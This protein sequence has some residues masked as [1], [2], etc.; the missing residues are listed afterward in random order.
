M[1]RRC[2]YV[3]AAVESG[4]EEEEEESGSSEYETDSESEDDVPMIKPVFVSK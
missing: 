1:M 2:D 3:G 4:D